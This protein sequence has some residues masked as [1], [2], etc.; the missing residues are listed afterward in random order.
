[1]KNR[2]NSFDIWRLWSKVITGVAMTSPKSE[3]KNLGDE[4]TQ[5]LFPGKRN[6][7]VKAMQTDGA[8]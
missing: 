7:L 8:H 5:P 1:L 4:A 3:E 6:M 2:E